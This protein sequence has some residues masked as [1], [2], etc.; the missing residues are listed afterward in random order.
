[1]VISVN[2]YD[3]SVSLPLYSAS[4]S[5][6]Y[7]LAPEGDLCGGRRSLAPHLYAVAEQALRRRMSPGY[8]Q[9]VL[10][11]GESGAGK[12][13]ALK[14]LL[15]Y[16]CAPPSCSGGEGG[17]GEGGVVERLVEMNPLLE[18][19][20]NAATV[21][22]HNSSRF[23]KL[24]TLHFHPPGSSCDSPITGGVLSSYL[25]E[26]LRVVRHA[27]GEGF[28]HVFY[29][30][31][32][33]LDESEVQRLCLTAARAETSASTAAHAT[34]AP[35]N[36]KSLLGAE[37][38]RMTLGAAEAV[39]LASAQMTCVYELLAAAIHLREIRFVE[40]SSSASPTG[41][42]PTGGSEGVARIAANSEDR[43]R[44]VA[45]LLGVGSSNLSDALCK[46]VL[47]VHGQSL[48]CGRSGSQ[49]RA[50]C[51][52]L[53]KRLYAMLFG[54][55]VE[56]VNGCIAPPDVEDEGS[57]P[58][59]IGLLDLFGFEN[60]ASNSF[61]QLCINYANEKLQ[62]QFNADV[63]AA[64]EAEAA[65]E[66]VTLSAADYE[67]NA[68]CVALLEATKP[69]PGVLLLLQEECA[70]GDGTDAN[71]LTKLAQL[72]LHSEH[73][74]VPS[75][76]TSA[77]INAK[78]LSSV[79]GAV[80]SR[81][82]SHS[83]SAARLPG[84][85]HLR[86]SN[87]GGSTAGA[88]GQHQHAFAVMHFAGEVWYDAIG[89]REKNSDVCEPQ[90][91]ELFSSAKHSLLPSLLAT[92]DSYRIDL[93]RTSSLD[94]PIAS[95]ATGPSR[96]ASAWRRAA[97][98]MGGAR[99]AQAALMS[100]AAER[101]K[102]SKTIGGQF[103]RQL[104]QLASTLADSECQYVRC[105]K[106]NARA[107]AAKWDDNFVAR[108]LANG[109][110]FAAARAARHGFDHRLEHVFFLQRYRCVGERIDRKRSADSPLQPQSP[111]S[112]F[113]AQARD[114]LKAQEWTQD[115]DQ[116]WLKT[117]SPVKGHSKELTAESTSIE[118]KGQVSALCEFLLGQADRPLAYQVGKTKVFLSSAAMETLDGLRAVRRASAAT[119]LQSTVRRLHAS[120]CAH[121][122]LRAV[123]AIQTGARVRLAR[124]KAAFVAAQL[125]AEALAEAERQRA[126]AAAKVAEEIAEAERQ[127]TEATAQA[128]AAM[129]EGARW[130][131]AM[132][133]MDDKIR[134]GRKELQA[135][136][137]SCSSGSGQSSP[138]ENAPPE[139]PARRISNEN[140]PPEP[141]ARRSRGAAG[142][143]PSPAFTLSPRPF[144]ERNANTTPASGKSGALLKAERSIVGQS[145]T[146]YVSPS[147]QHLAEAAQICAQ[148]ER[149]HDAKTPSHIRGM[150]TRLHA[151][152]DSTTPPKP[153]NEEAPASPTASPLSITPLAESLDAC[154]PVSSLH[155]SHFSPFSSPFSPGHAQAALA[156]ANSLLGRTAVA[157][158]A[159]RSL[160]A[161]QA[162]V[163]PQS[164]LQRSRRRIKRRA[165]LTVA[166]MLILM[167]PAVLLLAPADMQLHSVF[168]LGS[169]TP[170]APAP[171]QPKALGWLQRIVARMRR[172]VGMKDA[173][174]GAA[175]LVSTAHWDLLERRARTAE[176]EAAK[177]RVELH[178]NTQGWIQREKSLRAEL[179]EAR[180]GNAW[181]TVHPMPFA[182]K[183][184]DS[185][186]APLLSRVAL[187]RASHDR[188]FD[189]LPFEAKSI[190]VA[191]AVAMI[192][193]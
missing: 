114:W 46:R 19:F 155:S 137:A 190:G 183:W 29:Q 103:M 116:D 134:A 169:M 24:I 104:Q 106:P 72:H 80:V 165:F 87:L 148:I 86:A 188:R 9:S 13:E 60:F 192:F 174:H 150:L 34:R 89:F 49:A 147:Q 153:R 129:A 170:L 161:Q 66:G 71:F 30:M 187:E 151:L 131:E 76:T 53:T 167:L 31:V 94:E 21:L 123:V 61:E 54:W 124:R 109:G 157:H 181:S 27:E 130:G 44:M 133:A 158:D 185:A 146:T 145:P 62:A 113:V 140:A 126:E 23:G 26:K 85:A 91:V 39:G 99:R 160:L 122:R 55:I 102:P 119:T 176:G 6:A 63:F 96:D 120:I 81:S 171:H 173:K 16:L 58:H 22:N 105:I 101:R 84:A 45:T 17:E 98:Q 64:A 107:S 70:L 5:D 68:A 125:L 33:G 20:G 138:N 177:L 143:T 179:R 35:A 82:R 88:L 42:A 8:A 136:S 117:G 108:Q 184:R 52:A 93:S 162:A 12:T 28:F 37:A 178:R 141:P 14:I 18:A 139:P 154:T 75:G 193:G 164:L 74:H 43:L 156:A 142:M 67:D 41:G 112:K 111:V 36:G 168:G 189:H 51:D 172:L 32:D 2:P 135:Y 40:G 132:V 11:G 56:Q 121:A 79:S 90:H 182:S 163:S 25:L 144:G 152:R 4:T 3:W 59:T 180:T 78:R 175:H 95:E 92:A 77:A 10:I 97:K 48:E 127:R 47:L 186:A 166:L 100:G 191:E 38:W 1:M 115:W 110:I 50:S 57:S 118:P 73:L 83:L 15:R 65:A 149:M 159:A 69:R 7:R 128:A